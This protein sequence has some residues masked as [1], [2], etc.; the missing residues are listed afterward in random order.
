MKKGLVIFL[1]IIIVL[2][3]AFFYCRNWWEKKQL[4][5]EMGYARSE[6]PWRDYSQDELNKMYPQIKNA[7]VPTRT[8]PEETYAK[9]REALRTNNLNLAI[10]QLN[11]ESGRYEEN[12]KTLTDAYNEGKFPERIEK[13][14]MYEAIA[15]YYYLRNGFKT[16]ISFMKNENGDWGLEIF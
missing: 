5:I 3:S 4:K 15:S 7:D 14:S 1:S 11:K 8:A 13:E 12:R 10:E 16:H 6:F 9:F 2:A